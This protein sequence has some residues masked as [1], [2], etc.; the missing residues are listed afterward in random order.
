MNKEQREK[1]KEFFKQL[2]GELLSPTYRK[3]KSTLIQ[4]ISVI[5]IILLI[6][7]LG[8]YFADKF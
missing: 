3:K 5:T 2:H 6:I 1:E 7:A 8:Q 4:K